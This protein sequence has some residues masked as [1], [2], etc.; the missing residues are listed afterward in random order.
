M[1]RASETETN[2][3]REKKDKDRSTSATVIRQIHDRSDVPLRN[4]KT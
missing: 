2:R 4:E 1:Q 3:G